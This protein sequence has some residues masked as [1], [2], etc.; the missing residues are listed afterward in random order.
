M[1]EIDQEITVKV[2]DLV[3]A[4]GEEFYLSVVMWGDPKRCRFEMKLGK[5][6]WHS[7]EDHLNK[8]ED[9][10]AEFLEFLGERAFKIDEDLSC[11]KDR[12]ITVKGLP[13]RKKPIVDK[14]GNVA[15]PK[16]FEAEF[17]SELED[18]DR[19]GGDTYK[20]AVFKNVIDDPKCK[21]CRYFNTQIAKEAEEKQK[22]KEMKKAKS[23]EIEQELVKRKRIE[24]EKEDAEQRNLEFCGWK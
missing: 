5:T 13:N 24:K 6:L 9:D 8:L 10:D 19:V 4:K 11:L 20:E 23:V 21:E 2:I 22:E 16:I 7:I 17:R 18:A 15:Y 3:Y 1:P 14:K 12:I